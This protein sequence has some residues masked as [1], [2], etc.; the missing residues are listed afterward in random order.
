[1]AEAAIQLMRIARLLPAALIIPLPVGSAPAV[2]S[3]RMLLIVE[4]DAVAAHGPTGAAVLQRVAEARVPLAG[5]ED[6]R[7]I[8]F[9]PE[10]GGTEHLAIVIGTIDWQLRP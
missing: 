8:A 10:D 6:A 1:M 7:V 9:R 2:A 5:A 4:T 3:A